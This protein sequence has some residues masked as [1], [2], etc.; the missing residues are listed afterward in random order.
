[1]AVSPTSGLLG[2]IV[3]T[4]ERLIGYMSVIL[5][6]SSETLFLI[7]NN[8][9]VVDVYRVR[10]LLHHWRFLA[11]GPEMYRLRGVLCTQGSI[12]TISLYYNNQGLQP[13]QHLRSE[14]ASV[15]D[16][17]NMGTCFLIDPGRPL[18]AKWLGSRKPPAA[19]SVT[20]YPQTSSCHLLVRFAFSCHIR[21]R[22]SSH[23]RVLLSAAPTLFATSRPMSADPQI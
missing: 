10:F 12:D 15:V 14:N 11:A 17:I 9:E 22:P 18:F 13:S 21:K 1:M 16:I 8:Y 4:I 23:V 6:G 19:R 20:S 3:N 2:L 7:S 5:A